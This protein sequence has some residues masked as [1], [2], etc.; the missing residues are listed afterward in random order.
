[1]TRHTPQ[2]RLGNLRAR[3][4]IIA[5]SQEGREDRPPVVGMS[6]HIRPSFPVEV[7]RPEIRTRQDSTPQ[8]PAPVDERQARI[9]HAMSLISQA[10]GAGAL[11]VTIDGDDLAAALIDLDLYVPGLSYQE[12]AAAIIAHTTGARA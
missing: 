12:T 6:Q 5:L 8:A 4:A 3:Q 11:T 10:P 7:Q 9:N 2:D 1:M